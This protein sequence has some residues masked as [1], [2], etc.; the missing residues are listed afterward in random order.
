MNEER[1]IYVASLTDYNAGILHGKWFDLD[2]FADL[3]GLQEAIN[4][5]L[6]ESPIMK[7]TG[8]LAEE[9]VIYDHMGFHALI[10]EYMPLIEVWEIYSLLEEHADNEDALMAYVRWTGDTLA[11]AVDNFED[12]CQGEWDSE[13]AF[14]EDLLEDSGMLSELPDW[15]QQYFDM[16]KYTHDLFMTDYVYIDGFVFRNC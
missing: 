16:E 4:V 2:D 6:K 3:E 12:C 10:W 8:A 15:A 11:D 7:E 1:R 14:V 5:M 9:Y 13:E